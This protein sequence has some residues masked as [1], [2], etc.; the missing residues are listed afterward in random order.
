M[1]RFVGKLIASAA[2]AA[3][4]GVIAAIYSNKN[5]PEEDAKD[6]SGAQDDSVSFVAIDDGNE[7]SEPKEPQET[8]EQ[9]TEEEP[10][11]K[12]DG[13]AEVREDTA[14]NSELDAIAQLY[15]YLS[16][17]FIAS[18]FAK[19]ADY[20][21][22]YPADTLVRLVHTVS[23]E[24]AAALSSFEEI[25]RRRG[26]EIEPFGDHQVK[27]SRRLFTENGAILSDIYNVANQTACLKGSWL[28]VDI[29][30]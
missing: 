2:A 10:E 24:D 16:K 17:D 11:E 22:D 15:P 28:G 8:A 25:A 30:R 14:E 1:N 9:K 23:F 7:E 20:N 6:D 12:E 19:N 4:L 26:Y 5:E 27:V 29:V 18:Q 21:R 3:A 13:K